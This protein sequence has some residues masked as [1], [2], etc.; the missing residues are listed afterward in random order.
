VGTIQ[1][2]RQI[3]F[4][5]AS[6]STS[7]CQKVLQAV[8]RVK[9]SIFCCIFLY[10]FLHDFLQPFSQIRN[11]HQILRFFIPMLNNFKRKIVFVILALF[12]ILKTNSKKTAEKME[13]FFHEY[14]LELNFETNSIA[15]EN[16]VVNIVVPYFAAVFG[17]HYSDT[18]F[19]TPSTPLIST[20]IGMTLRDREI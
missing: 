18:I 14:V 10:N 4:I 20:G 8:I 12:T 11:Q 3:Y 17:Y 13:N 5:Q 19:I 7:I 15:W 9:N 6:S 1:L 16:Q 2:K